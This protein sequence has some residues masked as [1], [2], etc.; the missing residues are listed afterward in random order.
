MRYEEEILHCEHG[1]TVEWVAQG[2]CGF[3]NPGRV[4]DEVGCKA[5]SYMVEWDVSLTWQVSS[6]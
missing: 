4:Q 1:E 6:D 2:G 3:P 5:L